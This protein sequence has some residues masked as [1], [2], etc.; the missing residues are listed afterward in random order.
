MNPNHPR[1]SWSRLAAAARLARDDRDVTAP[2]G[3]STR[4]V[5]QAFASEGRVASLFD[6]FAFR[7]LG[8][9]CLLAAASVAV[10]YSAL[11]EP[12]HKSVEEEVQLTPVEDPVSV[13][14][15]A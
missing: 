2:Y 4:V 6:R 13:L 8:V 7:A 5:A 3:F 15:D 10:N 11:K 1:D 9:A 14:L 12:K